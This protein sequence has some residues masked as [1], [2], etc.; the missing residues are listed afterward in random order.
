MLVL[1]C[2]MLLIFSWSILWFFQKM[3]GW[4][5]F[6]PLWEVLS[7]FAYTQ[8][9]ALL[10]SLFVLL[11]LVLLAVILPP[12]FFR[13]SFVAQ[14]SILLF[15]AAFWIILFQSIWFNVVEWA[16]GK[17]FLWFTLALLTV[18]ISCFLVHRSKRLQRVL[19]AVADRISV[20]LYLYVPLGT[21]GLVV[22]IARNVL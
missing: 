20:F 9:F 2:C 5:P 21:L 18:L 11:L 19:N 8:M 7:I 12:R 4:L 17:L 22:V 1:A 13:D 6:L 10:E 14:G 16:A 15:I 3:P